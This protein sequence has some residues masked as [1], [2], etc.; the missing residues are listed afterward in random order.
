MLVWLAGE[1]R[2]LTLIEGVPSLLK[3]F[4]KLQLEFGDKK[5]PARQFLTVRPNDQTVKTLT[6]LHVS[7]LHLISTLC[8]QKTSIDLLMLQFKNK[9]QEQLR[10]WKWNVYFLFYSYSEW[11]LSL[12]NRTLRDDF[13][14]CFRFQMKWNEIILSDSLWISSC[15]SSLI[16]WSCT[17]LLRHRKPR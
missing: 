9:R 5:G 6:W 1:G 12:W 13:V 11:K 8:E 10:K 4:L 17:P 2:V 14:D 7:P 15:S 16:C 3:G